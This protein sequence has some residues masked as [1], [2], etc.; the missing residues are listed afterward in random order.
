MESD[1]EREDSHSPPSELFSPL[2]PDDSTLVAAERMCSANSDLWPVADDGRLVGVVCNR[3]PDYTTAGYGHDPA[4]V[5]IREIMSRDL[6]FCTEEQDRA[7]VQ[8]LMAEKGLRLLP[9]VNSTM[10]IIGFV[11]RNEA[12]E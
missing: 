2:S 5:R 9:V 11:T 1:R 4:S 3:H 12:E 7:E 8:R 6:I 10:Q